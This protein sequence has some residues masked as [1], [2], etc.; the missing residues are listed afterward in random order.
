VPTF[1]TGESAQRAADASDAFDLMRGRIEALRS[2][3]AEVRPAEVL[4]ELESA[5]EAVRVAEREVLAQRAEL[6]Q[7]IRG[8]HIA[9]TAQDRFIAVL[10]APVVVTDVQGVIQVANAAA[11]TLLG[12]RL[13]RLLRE[14]LSAFV[15]DRE[16]PALR[17]LL[18]GVRDEG[19]DLRTLSAISVLTP[20]DA[21]PLEVEMAATLQRDPT[22][23]QVHLTWVLLERGRPAEATPD[24]APGAR[25]ARTVVEL[26]RLPLVSTSVVDLLTR[27][28]RLCQLAFVPPVAVSISV[29]DPA[30]PDLLA[31]DSLLAQAVDGAQ[32]VAGE[33]PCALAW[34]EHKTVVSE[35]IAADP[36]WPR[37]SARLTSHPPD[38]PVVSAVAVPVTSGEVAMGAL[39]LYGAD[40]ALVCPESVEAA[41]MLSATISAILHEAEAKSELE[42][43]STQLQE[44]LDSRA[45]I[46][47]AKGIVM[48][49][50]GCGPDE[51]FQR[52][53]RISSHANVKL[54]DV[55]AQLVAATSRP[56]GT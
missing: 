56:K 52:L 28:A 54:R 4:A 11:A 48:A 23:H 47:Q 49:M 45:T 24:P 19:S 29:G 31:T 30:A 50:E 2:S 16:R 51:A 37:L 55:A 10:P 27:V 53:V 6:D 5:R 40:H 22:T 41:E 3:W 36:R 1:G 14:P 8:Q 9:R 43:M 21:P 42:R 26:T 44:A 17:S 13:D 33:G 7:L 12:V 18:Q 20:R 15:D 34:A 32:V 39:N 35:A 25:L 38:G 46:D